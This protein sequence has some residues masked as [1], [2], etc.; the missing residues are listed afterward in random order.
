MER[1]ADPLLSTVRKYVDGLA[2]IARMP[3]TLSV[4]VTAG[5]R[6]FTLTTPRSVEQPMTT[7]TFTATDWRLRAW[8]DAALEQRW[9]AE[10]VIAISEDE[11]GDLTQWPGDETLRRQLEAAFT[12]RADPRSKQAYG[13]FVRYWRYFRLDMQVG[14]LVA[15]PLVGRRVGIAKITGDYQ[16]RANEVDA[17]MRHIRPVRWIRLTD[18]ASLDE[19]LRKVVNAPGTVCQIQNGDLSTVA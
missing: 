2:A 1:S 15:V 12:E 7:T 4:A 10:N 18:R 6:S 14:D 11:V 19:P 5:D 8:D 13:T 3:V 17:R 9:L 16:Y